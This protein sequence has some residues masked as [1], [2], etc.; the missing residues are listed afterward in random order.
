MGRVCS[1]AAHC[2][3]HNL[4]VALLG[5]GRSGGGGYYR[6]AATGPKQTRW[7]AADSRTKKLVVHRMCRRLGSESDL[8]LECGGLHDTYSRGEV[9]RPH[10][11]SPALCMLI[12]LDLCRPIVRY[13]GRGIS[14]IL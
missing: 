1:E 12:E 6:G 10:P 11:P 14:F 3:R 4:L 8:H 9:H 13:V 5:F 2:C 7:R